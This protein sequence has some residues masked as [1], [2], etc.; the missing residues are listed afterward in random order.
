MK[1]PTKL[2]IPNYRASEPYG[3]CIYCGDSDLPLTDEHI[4]PQALGEGVF[5]PQR[6]LPHLSKNNPCI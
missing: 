1:T 4:V 3:K 6:L 2:I 5:Y